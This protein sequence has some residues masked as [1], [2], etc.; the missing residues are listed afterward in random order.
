MRALL[1]GV[2]A[3]L[4]SDVPRAAQPVHA[5]LPW[6]FNLQNTVAVEDSVENVARAPDSTGD[7]DSTC[8]FSPTQ[9]RLTA[10]VTGSPRP[11]TIVASYGEGI[12]VF[13]EEGRLI[14]S[15]PGYPCGGSADEIEVLAAGTAFGDRT[16]VVAVTTGGRREQLTWLAMFRVGFNGRLEAVFAGAVEQ[17]ADGDVAQGS[18]TVLPGAL[19]VRDTL[20]GVG[21][22]VFD[23]TAGVYLP[24]GG[25]GEGESHTR[26]N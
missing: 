25:H 12:H 17:R 22:W 5:A 2:I 8:S 14:G 20:G 11:E 23:P 1:L 7:R 3:V 10:D 26:S 19:L 4:A 18:V 16:I 6:L 24:P 15:T 13:N 9:L 21:Y